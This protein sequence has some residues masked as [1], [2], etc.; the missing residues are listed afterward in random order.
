MKTTWNE[1]EKIDLK[2]IWKIEKIGLGNKLDDIREKEEFRI[3]PSFS[4]G[5]LNGCGTVR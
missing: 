3:T 4:L 2:H 1:K 5:E